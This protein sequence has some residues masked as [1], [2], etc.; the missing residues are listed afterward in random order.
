MRRTPQ[1]DVVA[2]VRD[3]CTRLR[4]HPA[5]RRGWDVARVEADVR[6]A[7]AGAALDGARVPP[8]R[9]RELASGASPQ[10]PDEAVAR[11]GL[12]VRA[13]VTRG[14]SGPT[15]PLPKVPLGQL[16][17]SLHVAAGGDGRLRVADQPGDLRGL[18]EAPVG[19]RLGGALVELADLVGGSAGTSGLETA[20]AALAQLSLLRPFRDHN[21]VVARAVFRW[22]TITSGLDPSGLAMPEVAWAQDPQGFLGTLAG[23]S[24]AAGWRPWVQRCADAL[25][26]G[27]QAAHV[28]A[29]DVA[30]GRLT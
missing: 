6:A 15:A 29:D 24:T 17:V 18:G 20:A 19:P 23:A 21:A 14:W 2:S 22:V 27:A 30:A 10:G 1:D 4:W 9:V 11:A 5:L 25:L 26:G 12:R 28:V 8:A 13:A 16:V 7:S 3:A